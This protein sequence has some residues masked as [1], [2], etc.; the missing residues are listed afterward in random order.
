[1]T[2]LLLG[3]LITAMK[4]PGSAG[5][6]E[7]LSDPPAFESMSVKGGQVIRRSVVCVDHQVGRL[8]SGPCRGTFMF[9]TWR[10]GI[11]PLQRTANV[12]HVP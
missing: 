11:G 6:Q 7:A 8:V 2:S 1:M 4:G 3:A 9:R 5:A 10:T 12:Q